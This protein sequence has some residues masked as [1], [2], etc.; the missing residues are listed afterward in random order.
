M[1]AAYQSIL[2]CP[3]QH[4][5]VDYVIN[6]WMQDQLGRT[7]RAP[8]SG[9]GTAWC[10]VLSAGAEITLVDAQPGLPDMVFTA[11]AGMVRAMLR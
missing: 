3:P 5:A 8:P 11:N 7:D 10:Q 4:Y 9:N 6:P 2:M 1:L